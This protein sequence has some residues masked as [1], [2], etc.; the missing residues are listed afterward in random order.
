MAKFLSDCPGSC[1]KTSRQVHDDL[2]WWNNLLPK[3]NGVLFFEEKRQKTY[4]LYIDG[5]LVSFGDFY[6]K[7]PSAFRANI[8]IEQNTT[9]VVTKKNYIGGYIPHGSGKSII[10]AL[11]EGSDVQLQLPV[12]INVSELQA[13][14]LRF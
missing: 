13:I 2:S 4:Q 11:I 14:T 6:Y 10:C 5:S 7:H 9:F 1:W 12:S 3:F 8:T